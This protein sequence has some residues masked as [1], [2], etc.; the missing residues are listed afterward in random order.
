MSS[1]GNPFRSSSGYYSSGVPVGITHEDQP[2]LLGVA[3]KITLEVLQRNTKED[4]R[5]IPSWTFSSNFSR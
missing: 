3:P 4:A 5:G 1:I 2:G